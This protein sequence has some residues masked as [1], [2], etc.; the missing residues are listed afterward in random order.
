MQE[1]GCLALHGCHDPRVRVPGGDHGDSGI[2]VEEAIPVYIFDDCAFTPLY[3]E[4]V[5]SRIGWG[6]QR[7]IP[8]DNFRRL[9]PWKSGD[10]MRKICDDRS[11]CRHTRNLS[12]LFLFWEGE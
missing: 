10:Q 9:G 7:L 6:E 1:F 11:L 5:A 3:D 4:R 2:E 12:I 8:M